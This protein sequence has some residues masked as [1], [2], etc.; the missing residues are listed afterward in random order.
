MNCGILQ[1][2]RAKRGPKSGHVHKSVFLI[3]D[4][5]QIVKAENCQMVKWKENNSLPREDIK[6]LK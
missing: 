2:E 6:M 1:Y 4:T 3:H 5:K